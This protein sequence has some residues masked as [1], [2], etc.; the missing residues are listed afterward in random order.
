MSIVISKTDIE[1]M[2]SRF[3]ATFINSIE[4]FKSLNLVATKSLEGISNVAP[5]NSIMHIGS[6]PPLIG[7]LIRPE[8][9]EHQTLKNIRDTKSFTINHINENILQ[10]AHQTS[11]KYDSITSEF[12][13][14]GLTEQTS[15]HSFAPYV[16]ESNLKY[17]LT[18]K[19]IVP[20]ALN[21]MNLVIG[22]I[23]EVLIG[24]CNIEDDGYVHIEE[25][26]TLTCVGVDSYF[27]VSN[28]TRLPYAKK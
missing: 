27:N 19:E 22:E 25:L 1:N 12:D 2:N 20:I 26:G 23:Q 15:D 14:C 17:T 5:F 13:A 24:E 4:G 6:N 10:Q 28:I 9:D 7:M 8:T 11:A 18:L 16:K 21:G 3:R